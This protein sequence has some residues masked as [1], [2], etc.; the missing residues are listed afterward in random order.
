MNNKKDIILK[1]IFEC[2]GLTTLP[3]TVDEFK[4]LNCFVKG[5]ISSV[6]LVLGEYPKYEK[7]YMECFQAIIQEFS[8][9]L[10]LFENIFNELKKDFNDNVITKQ[11]YYLI[12]QQLIEN[13]TRIISYMDR[14]FQ[15]IDECNDEFIKFNLSKSISKYR[16][17]LSM[18]DKYHHLIDWSTYQEYNDI[19]EILNHEEDYYE[20]LESLVT[21]DYFIKNLNY[22]KIIE[23]RVKEGEDMNDNILIEMLKDYNKYQISYDNVLAYCKNCYLT[24]KLVNYICNYYTP[25]GRNWMYNELPKLLHIFID[26][27]LDYRLKPILLKENAFFKF[28]GVRNKIRKKYKYNF[29]IREKL[30]NTRKTILY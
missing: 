28:E 27:I 26:E 18:L 16:I 3:S 12:I 5:D 8:F 13:G 17:N 30:Y 20:A 6:L 22:K 21:K 23:D 15:I 7:M 19:Y 11:N 2:N 24:S 25:D 14:Y 10:N 29:K 9:Q 1:N 4:Q